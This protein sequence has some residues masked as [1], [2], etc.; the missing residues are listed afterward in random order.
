MQWTPVYCVY[1]DKECTNKDRVGRAVIQEVTVPFSTLNQ[2]SMKF[3]S[4]LSAALTVQGIL[5]WCHVGF[6]NS[7]S[8]KA[9][10]HSIGHHLNEV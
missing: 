4:T 5:Q 3:Y 6:L 2:T 10:V 1:S 7:V 9:A 8:G